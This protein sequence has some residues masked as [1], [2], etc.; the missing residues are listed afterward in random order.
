MRHNVLALA[1]L[2]C[3]GLLAGE[4]FPVP[5]LPFQPLSYTCHHTFKEIRIDGSLDE[6]DWLEASWT[7]LF[8]DIEGANRPAPYLDTQVKMLWDRQGLYIAARL[9][10]PHIWATLT[11]HDSVI[12]QDNDFKVFI[13]PDGNTHGYAE[14]EINAWGAV[15][16]LFLVKPYRDEHAPITGWNCPGLES[17]V[18][19]EGTLNDPS[20]TDLEW[21]VEM[22]IPW[23]A[24]AEFAHKPCPPEEGDYWRVNFARVQWETEILDGQYVKIPGKTEH[25]WVWSP[26]GLVN[27]HYPERWGYLFFTHTP[28]GSPDPGFIIPAQEQAREYLRQI[29][30]A[31]RQHWLDKGKY[32]KSLAKLGMKPLELEG[33]RLKPKIEATSRTWI[34][35]LETSSGT[36]LSIGTDGKLVTLE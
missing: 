9:Y 14:I 30:Y 27:M 19:I 22:L 24:L 5:E 29:Y 3:C 31:Q 26:Q 13:D 20:D 23:P 2:L 1:I 17:A 4:T 36:V 7:E 33:K 18:G 16:D 35:S 25:N 32:A 21:T 8:T 12:F 6:V 28:V 34:A 11:Q 10:D 15:W